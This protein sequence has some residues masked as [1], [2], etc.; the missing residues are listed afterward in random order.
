MHELGLGSS[1]QLVS[2]LFYSGPFRLELI[3][4]IAI[5]SNVIDALAAL[6]LTNHS[7]KL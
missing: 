1:F 6:F 5:F 7:V 2:W 3:I 4:A